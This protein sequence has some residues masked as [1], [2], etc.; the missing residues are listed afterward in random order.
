ML[1]RA[2]LVDTL[3][4]ATVSQAGDISPRTLY[5]LR[6][7]WEQQGMTGLLRRETGMRNRELGAWEMHVIAHNSQL[8]ETPL[9]TAPTTSAPPS[10]NLT[11]DML[12][13]LLKT[14]RKQTSFAL[15]CRPEATLLAPHLPDPADRGRLLSHALTTVLHQAD[16]EIEG[17]HGAKQ[18]ATRH[19]LDGECVKTLAMRAI[20]SQRSVHYTLSQALAYAVE[21]LPDALNHVDIRPV[22]TPY[23][24]DEALRGHDDD[25]D[26]LSNQLIVTKKL[27]LV[28]DDWTQQKNLAA[29]LANIWCHAGWNV[30]WANYDDGTDNPLEVLI[31]ALYTQLTQVGVLSSVE[32][33]GAC[34][35]SKRIA[36]LAKGLGQIPTL[37]V[38]SAVSIADTDAGLVEVLAALAYEND[39]LHMLIVSQTRLG[40]HYAEINVNELA[41][42]AN[43]LLERVY[44]G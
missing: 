22:W 23:I 32:A 9:L 37:L 16:A 30:V 27:W 1:L 11:S 35:L 19:F 3:S 18:L 25:V 4:V 12:R 41:S 33:Y 40:S 10:I 6:A 44:G 5:R 36:S 39:G 31:A 7:C 34:A 42:A 13:C 29:Q 15:G 43:N 21:R 8:S 24:S 26:L 20:M 14:M 2:W 38:I 17:R 28:G